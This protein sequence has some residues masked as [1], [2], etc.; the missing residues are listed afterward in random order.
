MTLGNMRSCHYKRWAVMEQTT[1]LAELLQQ[2]EKRYS[3]HYTSW[4]LICL[5]L[6]KGWA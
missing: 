5:N 2:A 3:A 6:F 1:T 4:H